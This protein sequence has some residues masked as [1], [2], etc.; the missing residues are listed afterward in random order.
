M[1]TAV[2]IRFNKLTYQLTHFNGGEHTTKWLSEDE[3]YQDDNKK[4]SVGFK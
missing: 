1:I 3:F 2:E 4:V